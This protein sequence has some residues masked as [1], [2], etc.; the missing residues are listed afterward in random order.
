[1]KDATRRETSRAVFGISPSSAGA[2]SA[3]RAG[4]DTW[5]TPT[6]QYRK[7]TQE[8]RDEAVL[9]VIQSQRP[10]AQVVA[11]EPG[12]NEGTLGE[13]WAIYAT[14]MIL[15]PLWK[16]AGALTRASK[17]KMYADHI[18]PTIR[19]IFSPTLAL[20]RATGPGPCSAAAAC[21]TWGS[22]AACRLLTCG[23]WT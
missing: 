10:I 17:V 3:Q 21:A 23:C 7:L 2:S 4:G 22:A 11:R 14:I 6:G 9:M 15:S 5:E 8:Y 18:V 13:V 1:V 16:A 12:I 19:V 20:N